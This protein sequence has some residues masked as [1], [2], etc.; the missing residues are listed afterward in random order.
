MTNVVQ[1]K[2][3]P[4]KDGKGITATQRKALKFI[5]AHIKIHGEWPSMEDI[6]SVCGIYSTLGIERTVARLEER[7]M[8]PTRTK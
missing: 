6:G 5:L 1:L 4:M 7:G 2:L 8:V 3:P